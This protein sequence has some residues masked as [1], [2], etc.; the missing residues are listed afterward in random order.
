[1]RRASR[2]NCQF[3][4]S[5]LVA[6]VANHFRAHSFEDLEGGRYTLKLGRADVVR[7]TINPNLKFDTEQANQDWRKLSMQRKWAVTLP[8]S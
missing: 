6:A 2:V 7:G 8:Q 1:M 3:Q 4:R 5:N